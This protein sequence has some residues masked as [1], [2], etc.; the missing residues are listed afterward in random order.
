MLN[1]IALGRLGNQMFQYAS[2]R[3]IQEK[4]FCEDIINM[5]FSEVRTLGKK[6]DG[7]DNQL[8][9][10]KLND[11]KIVFDKEIVFNK[12]QKVYFFIYNFMHK[13][14]RLLYGKK[15]FKIKKIEFEKNFQKKLNKCGLFL[16]SY[17][18]YEF[19]NT[20]VENK[21]FRGYFESSKY[22]NDIRD[23]LLEEFTP[24]K[25]KIEK[26]KELYDDIEN[27]ESVCISIRRGDFLA[28]KHK[29]DCFVCDNQYFNN[30]MDKIKTYVNNPKF[31]VFSDDIEWCKKNMKFPDGTKFEAGDDPVWEKLRLMYSCKHF[32]ISNST[33]SW[34]AQYL[35]R[36]KGK[37]VIAPSRW[38]NDDY[39]TDIYEKNWKLI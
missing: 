32:I 17:G 5:N 23:I 38:R 37:V 27:S 34:W 2:L 18:F 29:R 36:N 1:N 26:N 39:V 15:K 11:K 14:I 16:Y 6:E 30:A 8:S 33:F 22:F 10:F 13:V 28:K 4:L 24:K 7:F 3:A 21:V 9:V 12:K 35:S 25:E 19:S 20:N 31:I